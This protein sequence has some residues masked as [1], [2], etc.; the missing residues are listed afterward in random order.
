MHSV[1]SVFASKSGNTWPLEKPFE[2]KKGKYTLIGASAFTQAWLMLVRT[3]IF[4]DSLRRAE[5][6]DE[7]AVEEKV[8]VGEE[9]YRPCTLP[10]PVQ[11][12]LE[13]RGWRTVLQNTRHLTNSLW[14]LLHQLVSNPDNI[15]REMATLNIDLKRMPLGSSSSCRIS[16]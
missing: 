3:T 14:L 11:K 7:D 16:R 2:K 13:V 10:T 1:A 15:A 8:A 12:L 4:T 9:K 5:M 6:E